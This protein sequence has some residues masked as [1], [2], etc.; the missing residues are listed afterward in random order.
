MTIDD[1]KLSL[2]L[3]TALLVLLLGS[4]TTGPRPYPAPIEHRSHRPYAPP[5][6]PPTVEVIPRPD[7]GAGFQHI[8]ED[9]YDAGDDYGFAPMED[10]A[11]E[12]LTVDEGQ[13]TSSE[14][15]SPEPEPVVASPV[16][17]LTDKARQQAADSQY[18]AAAGSLERA[19]RIE[20]NDPD[21]WVE[22]AKVRL[23]QGE[24]DE[25]GDLAVKSRSLAFGRPDLQARSWRLLAKVR[26]QQ[27]DIDGADQALETAAELD[28]LIR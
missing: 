2:S 12:E 22:L 28:S 1:H 14:R 20:P 25:A 3:I 15:P 5:Q 27:G 16:H 7:Y 24:I 11:P 17:A 13:T 18:E 4:C 10:Q 23:A 9:P 19:L 21:L 6:P 26:E 8:P